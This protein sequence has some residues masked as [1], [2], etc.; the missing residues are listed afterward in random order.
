MLTRAACLIADVGAARSAIVAKV[1]RAAR[2]HANPRALTSD[3]AEQ[4]A[5]ARRSGGFVAPTVRRAG[6]AALAVVVRI[7]RILRDAHAVDHAAVARIR[8]ALAGRLIAAVLGAVQIVVAIARRG[9]ARARAIAQL[10][11]A[12]LAIRARALGWLER[13]TV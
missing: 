6:V 2:A 12:E 1:R 5:R 13:P 4:T 10:G 3:Q 7:H 9:D 11:R 8:D